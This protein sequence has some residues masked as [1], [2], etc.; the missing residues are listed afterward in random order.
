MKFKAPNLGFSLKC[1]LI[2]LEVI[3]LTTY[4][5]STNFTR[6]SVH[7]ENRFFPAILFFHLHEKHFWKA[8]KGHTT[9]FMDKRITKLDLIP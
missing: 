5:R 7:N 2:L 4:Y 3:N 6:E 1:R 9:C 8:L